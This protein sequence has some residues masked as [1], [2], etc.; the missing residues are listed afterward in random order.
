MLR[1]FRPTDLSAVM[2]LW[3]SGNQDAHPFV[4]PAYWRDH[5][6]QVAQQL[7]QAEVWV[8][9]A[10]GTLLAFAGMTGDYLAG[11]FVDRAHRSAGLGKALLDHLKTRHPTITLQVYQKNHRAAAFYR[12]EGFTCQAQ[13]TDPGTGEAEWTMV[14][15]GAE[16]GDPP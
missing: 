10:Q 8:W 16:K 12:R 9:E 2:A 6:A 4:P 15:Q 14:W 5:S 7:P 3:L 13:G 1:P 11:L